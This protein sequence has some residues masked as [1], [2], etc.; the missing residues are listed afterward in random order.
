MDNSQ[1]ILGLIMIVVCIGS[2]L[3]STLKT[4]IVGYS[5]MSLLKSGAA[6]YTVN[7]KRQKEYYAYFG[8]I[9]AVNIIVALLLTRDIASIVTFTVFNM[10]FLTY[11]LRYW[12]LLQPKK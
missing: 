12:I 11:C 10:I 7:Q 3:A 1:K 4:G 9:L 8:V 5:P 2:W 6:K